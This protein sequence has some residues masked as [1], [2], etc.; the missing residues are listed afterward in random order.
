MQLRVITLGGRTYMSFSSALH[1]PRNASGGLPHD[2]SPSHGSGRCTIHAAGIS[3]SPGVTGGSAGRWPAPAFALFRAC[4]PAHCSR[5]HSQRV[6]RTSR[7]IGATLASGER[8][9][10]LFFGAPLCARA[11]C[12]RIQLLFF[13]ML[14]L[15]RPPAAPLSRPSRF[16]LARSFKDYSFCN[17]LPECLGCFAGSGWRVIC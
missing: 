12:S 15:R 7:A 13:E 8:I 10:R 17:T 2:C 14:V 3:L 11:Q 5:L 4:C 16:V 6:S 9:A 1:L